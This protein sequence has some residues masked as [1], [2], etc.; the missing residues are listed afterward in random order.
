MTI[1]NHTFPKS[2]FLASCSYDSDEQELS[3]G[4]HNGKVY[5]YKEVPFNTYTDL[6]TAK[7]AGG[8]FASIKNSLVQK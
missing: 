1:Y 5:Y 4:F 8:Y 2:S 7:S 3:I 6:T